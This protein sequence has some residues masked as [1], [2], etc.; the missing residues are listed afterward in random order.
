M[1]NALSLLVA[2]AAM[3]STWW[4][5]G[6]FVFERLTQGHRGPRRH[7]RRALSTDEGRGTSA[8]GLGLLV[9]A[10]AFRQPHDDVAVTLQARARP[11]DG[12]GFFW[13]IAGWPVPGPGI[14]GRA[15]NP[16]TVALSGGR[17]RLTRT[18]PK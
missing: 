16:V 17:Q 11:S 14:F 4:P 7:G 12:Q 8:E 13:S 6:T 2:L 9:R 1:M 18:C 10:V 15:F 5:F 3:E